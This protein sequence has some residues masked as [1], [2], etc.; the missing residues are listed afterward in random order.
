MRTTSDMK[1]KDLRVRLNREMFKYIRDRAK[2]NG[3]SASEYMR[4]LIERD[5]VSKNFKNKK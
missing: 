1:D 4:V 3:M 2:L 5:M